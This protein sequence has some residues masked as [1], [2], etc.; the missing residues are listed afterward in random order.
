MLKPRVRCSSATAFKVGSVKLNPLKP[1]RYC[2]QVDTAASLQLRS[3][4][5]QPS[6]QFFR[7]RVYP[8]PGRRKLADGWEAR[9]DIPTP[10]D[11]SIACEAEDGLHGVA[12]HHGRDVVG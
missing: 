9:R 5:Q 7:A 4:V 2:A 11:Q 3:G 8:P 1:G 12:E 6:P 10:M